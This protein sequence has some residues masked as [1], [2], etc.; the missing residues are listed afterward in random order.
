MAPSIPHSHFAIQAFSLEGGRCA[1]CDST[2]ASDRRSSLL[3]SSNHGDRRTHFSS[4]RARP[5]SSG[6]A[7]PSLREVKRIPREKE[8]CLAHWSR[9]EASACAVCRGVIQ[10]FANAFPDK[11]RD[12]RRQ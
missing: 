7:E 3:A 8:L 6:N 9:H 1:L 4:G 5:E 10:V 12:K 11:N 2:A